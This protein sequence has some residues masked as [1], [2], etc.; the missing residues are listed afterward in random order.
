MNKGKRNAGQ[1]WISTT[2]NEINYSNAYSGKY[3]Q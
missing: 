3:F 2:Q 1:G